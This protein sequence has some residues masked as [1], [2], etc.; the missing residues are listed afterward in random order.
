MNDQ[1]LNK[2]KSTHTNKEISS[3][4]SRNNLEILN[5][6]GM[7]SNKTSNNEINYKIVQLFKKIIIY[8]AK[9]EE[10]KNHI[11]DNNP[12][13][14]LISI[15]ELYDEN[16]DGFLTKNEFIDMILDVGFQVP[17]TQLQKLML[18]LRNSTKQSNKRTTIDFEQFLTLFYPLNLD[19]SY[20]IE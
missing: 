6:T 7:L 5:L 20:L 15:F 8:G 4:K 12:K 3:N 13:F 16:N 14:D 17:E 2:I 10:L 9:I 18:Y 19:A 1:D 11:F